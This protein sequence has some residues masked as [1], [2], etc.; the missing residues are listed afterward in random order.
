M[1]GTM[2]TNTEL[3]EVREEIITKSETFSDR[4]H[5]LKTMVDQKFRDLE[6]VVD[7]IHH[8]LEGIHRKLDMR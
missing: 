8:D 2:K 3:S 7:R 6:Y 4:I 1:W 5:E